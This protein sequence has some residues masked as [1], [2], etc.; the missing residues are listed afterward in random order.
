M[1]RS[2][3]EKAILYVNVIYFIYLTLTISETKYSLKDLNELNRSLI[4]S[5][6]LLKKV[7][8][9]FLVIHLFSFNFLFN[10]AKLRLPTGSYLFTIK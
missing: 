7:Y 6:N 8:L 2:D 9:R 10:L 5:N 4:K 3:Q 1:I